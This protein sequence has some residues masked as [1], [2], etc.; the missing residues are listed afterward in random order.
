MLGAVS[1][2]L[3]ARGAPRSEDDPDLEAA[4]ANLS[5]RHIS[6]HPRCDTSGAQG[7][8]RVTLDAP[9]HWRL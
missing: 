8:N 2:N 7:A 6:H 4:A 9:R 3:V 5:V 1:A